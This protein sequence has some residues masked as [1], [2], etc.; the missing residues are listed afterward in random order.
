MMRVRT[1]KYNQLKRS[2]ELENMLKKSGRKDVFC[3]FP[4]NIKNFLYQNFGVISYRTTADTILRVYYW[5]L[6]YNELNNEYGSNNSII[7]FLKNL[8]RN[9]NK[10]HYI[11]W[12]E[13]E[14]N[15]I[16]KVFWER[17]G[18]MPNITLKGLINRVEKK[19][20]GEFNPS[21]W[22]FPNDILDQYKNSLKVLKNKL[23][24]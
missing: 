6:H 7:S 8:S 9:K 20:I 24:V 16:R 11:Q 1:Q 3:N 10:L 5:D 2:A 21:N 22:R 19:G 4:I 15:V 13:D 17:S 23:E 12:T 14:Y 18:D